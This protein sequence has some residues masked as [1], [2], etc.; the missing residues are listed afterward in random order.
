MAKLT[1]QQIKHYQAALERLNKATLTDED[2]DFIY[3]H[4]RAA[5]EN[6][7][8]SR[9]AYFTPVDLAF[10]FE[11]D[12]YSSGRILD[13]C[14]GTG[15]LS[16]AVSNRFFH[17]NSGALPDITAIEK[18]PAFIA[19]GRK[20]LPWVNW[21]EADIFDL[22]SL[23]LGHFDSVIANPPFGRVTT[24]K[25]KNR[26]TGANFE[27]CLIDM[28]SDHADHGTFIIPQVSAPFKFSGQRQHVRTHTTES[29]KFFDQTGLYLSEGI[30]VDCN[31][32][33][34]DWQDVAPCVEIVTVDYA[35]AREESA[36]KQAPEQFALAF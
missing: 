32:H 8:S 33:R 7:V 1:K 4:W 26:Y 35:V 31:V 29:Q 18:N 5:A 2:R 19:L 36:V 20:L 14:A 17:R 25:T 22:P 27:L 23:G 34:G 6:E 16:W 24:P 30:G 13:A 21:I 12:V 11:F 15:V 10:D 3:T 9:S 28:L